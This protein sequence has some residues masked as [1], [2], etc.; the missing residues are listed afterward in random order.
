MTTQQSPVVCQVRF[1]LGADHAFHNVTPADAYVDYVIIDDVCVFT[2]ITPDTRSTINGA[3]EVIAAICE[4][5]G[6]TPDSLRFFDLQTG[7][8]YSHHRKYHPDGYDYDEVT[9][10]WDSALG[11]RRGGITGVE[12]TKA[13]CPANIQSIFQRYI[14]K[15]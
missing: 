6:I 15:E 3:G 10:R 8:S 1:Y 14:R 4:K 9:F 13:E 12:W 5:E 7:Q 11:L 2:G